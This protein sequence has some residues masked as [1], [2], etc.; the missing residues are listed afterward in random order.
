MATVSFLV[1]DGVDKGRSFVG[2][3]TPVTIGREEG[4]VVRL[5]DERVSRF[6]AKVQDD[7]EQVV[8]TDLESTNGTS[9]NG[10]P[11]QLRLLRPGDRVAVGRSVLVFGTIEEIAASL[12][13]GAPSAKVADVD[14]TMSNTRDDESPPGMVTDLF[15]SDSDFDVEAEAEFDVF[16]RKP[17]DLPLRL[18]P[19]QAAQLSEV[20]DYLQRAL[21][22]ATDSVHLPPNAKDARLPIE[23]WHRV[24]TVLHFLAQ[25]SRKVSEPNGSTMVD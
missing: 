9:V 23:N 16:D 25:Y 6:H 2:L 1:V 7:Q 11:V 3:D 24:Q 10:E 22:A 19:A 5:N 8:L 12:K 17:P 4:N 18:S 13:G 20:L 14:V 15:S 21:A